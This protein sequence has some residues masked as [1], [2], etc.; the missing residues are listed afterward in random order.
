[1]KINIS[2]FKTEVTFKSH[3][4]GGFEVRWSVPDHEYVDTDGAENWSDVEIGVPLHPVLFATLVV[5]IIL[6]IIR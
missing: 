3:G 6:I 2:R 4:W 5:G 1:M